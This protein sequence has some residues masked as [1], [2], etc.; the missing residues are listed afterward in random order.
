MFAIRIEFMQ[1]IARVCRHDGIVILTTPNRDA[2]YYKAALEDYTIG[3][4]H[5]ALMNYDELHTCMSSFLSNV[6]IVG[7]ETS[8]YPPL[9]GLIRSQAYLAQIQERAKAFPLTAS[10]LVGW[11]Q[12]DKA[13]YESAKK[14]WHLDE[15]IWSSARCEGHEHGESLRLFEGVFGVNVDPS[16]SLRISARCTD[17]V[18]LFWAHDWSGIAAIKVDG[19][20]HRV[21]L[22][23]PVGGFR[24]V[25]IG[26]L[27][28]GVHTVEVGRTGERRQQSHFDQV[29]FYKLLAYTVSA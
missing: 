10:G 6:S 4:E 12:V 3:P 1:E 28:P 27:N 2:I 14:V 18:F 26:S 11:G 17:L 16:H 13:R 22:F 23:S 29:V 9:D 15:V 25:K 7:F 5:I 21:D 19:K 20:E 24:R 8:L